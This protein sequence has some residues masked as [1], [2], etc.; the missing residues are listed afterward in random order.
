MMMMLSVLFGSV[1]LWVLCDIVENSRRFG[2]STIILPEDVIVGLHLIIIVSSYYCDCPQ[3]YCSASSTLGTASSS[4]YG[5]IVWHALIEETWAVLSYE[6][7]QQQSPFTYFEDGNDDDE[8]KRW[9]YCTYY[10][11]DYYYWCMHYNYYLHHTTTFVF[12]N[13]EEVTWWW[14]QRR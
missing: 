9:Y 14:W 4:S 5:T 7:W 10:Y 1:W 11:Y 6:L 2:N 13:D 3:R 8:D 12:S